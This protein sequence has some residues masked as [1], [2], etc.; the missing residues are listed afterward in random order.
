MIV[1]TGATGRLGRLIIEALL[2]QTDPSN[3]AAVV[4]SPEKATDL[5]T[6]GISLHQGDYADKASLEAAFT[7][8]DALMF[9]SNADIEQRAVQHQ[10]VVDAA[11]AAG[12]GRVVY[13]SVFNVTHEN[14]L[15]QTH[16]ATEQ[17]II[18]S[19]IPYTFLRN[20]FYMDMYVVEVEIA[21]QRG[22]YRSPSGNAGVSLVA[23]R[24]IA[25]SAAVVLTSDGHAG[26]AYDMTGPASVTP[27]VF[28]ET[29]SAISGQPIVY[30]PITWEELAAEYR[31]R[32]MPEAVVSLSIMLEQTI[33]S[34]AFAGVSNDIEQITGMP[35]EDFLSFSRRHLEE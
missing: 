9:I 30:Q 28:A 18:A 24:D 3:I 4:R 25:R 21:I 11:A 29:A 8:A 10:N 14:M 13:T 12:V 35:A 23:R 6:R 22:A 17:A 16:L 7:G 5:A 2:T 20:S 1:V 33:A 31:Q 26:K 27:A 19:G 32:G 15:A 34:R